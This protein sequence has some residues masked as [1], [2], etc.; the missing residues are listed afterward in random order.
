MRIAVVSPKPT[1][2]KKELTIRSREISSILLIKLMLK[3][4]K[5]ST[6][7]Q[8]CS[9]SLKKCSK[10]LASTKKMRKSFKKSEILQK[11]KAYSLID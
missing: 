6:E 11:R 5:L 10:H 9:K 4:K 7:F 8:K 3:S 1:Y 2:S